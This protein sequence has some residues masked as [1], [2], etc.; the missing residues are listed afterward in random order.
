[1]CGIWGRDQR[2]GVSLSVARSVYCV[3]GY[4][5][6]TYSQFF[7]PLAFVLEHRRS[8]AL[9][10]RQRFVHLSFGWVHQGQFQTNNALCPSCGVQ[11][12][13]FATNVY[14]IDNDAIGSIRVVFHR[15]GAT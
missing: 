4:S 7:F 5:G 9:T 14:L 15:G 8:F 6:Q 10:S 1:M 3:F 11:A 12:D 13:K 2:S